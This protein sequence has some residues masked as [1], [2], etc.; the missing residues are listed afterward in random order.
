MKAGQLLALSGIAAL[1]ATSSVAEEPAVGD[2]LESSTEAPFR[3]WN[4]LV[5][6]IGIYRQS[7]VVFEKDGQYIV[8]S[9]TPV[10][11]SERGGFEIEKIIA[12][13]RVLPP[14]N[15]ENVDGHNCS[16]LG[17]SPAL[18]FANR[19]TN[20][21]IAYFALDDEVVMKRWMYEDRSECEYGG[22]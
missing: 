9:T 13:R 8:A 16:F 14:P 4:R 11:R 2:L 10:K 17:L 6:A 12:T 7:Y 3:T 15:T 22:D 21:V 19:S 1:W 5:S 18:A 20:V